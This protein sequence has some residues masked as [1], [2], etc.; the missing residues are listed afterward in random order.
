MADN[1]DPT[2]WS[3]TFGEA[4]PFGAGHII[5]GQK[6]TLV[7]K[8]RDLFIGS[9]S[10]AQSDQEER[11]VRKKNACGKERL[12]S[13]IAEIKSKIKEKEGQFWEKRKQNEN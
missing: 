10:S 12:E 2:R 11:R 6:S 13:E 8:T 3:H 1:L 9:G 7:I 5:E 4:E